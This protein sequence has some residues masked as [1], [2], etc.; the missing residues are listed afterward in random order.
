MLVYGIRARWR[1]DYLV[2]KSVSKK[3][4]VHRREKFIATWLWHLRWYLGNPGSIH[5]GLSLLICL[6]SPIGKTA[7]SPGQ[8]HVKLLNMFD[9]CLKE[10]T[11]LSKVK[12]KNQF[13]KKCN[14]V[15][16][17]K[18]IKTTDQF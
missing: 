15:S 8:L 18:R 2:Q 10:I 11:F 17:L 9:S 1:T 12:I 7:L 4:N 13:H 16:L 6:A 3:K 14:I 5:G